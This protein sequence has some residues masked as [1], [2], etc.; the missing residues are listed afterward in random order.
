MD[1]LSGLSLPGLSLPRSE[2]SSLREMTH[3]SRPPASRLEVPVDELSFCH[4]RTSAEIARIRHLRSEIQLPEAV[5]A[6]PGFHAREKKETNRGL[7]ARLRC[8]DHSSE[9]SASFR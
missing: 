2:L 1:N 6:D 8:T 5:L 3:S 7:L 9:L 4:L